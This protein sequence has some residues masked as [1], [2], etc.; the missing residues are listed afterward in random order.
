MDF[1]ASGQQAAGSP[2]IEGKPGLTRKALLLGTSLFV[3]AIAPSPAFAFAGEQCGPAPAGPGT[4][5]CT[6]AGNPYPTGIDY[7]PTPDDLTLVLDPGVV[8]VQGVQLTSTAP[9]A[10]LRVEGPVYTSIYSTSAG[11]EGVL[12]TSPNGSAYVN[13]DHVTTLGDNAIGISAAAQKFTTVIADTVLTSGTTS[14]GVQAT[15]SPSGSYAGGPVSVTVADLTTVGDNSHGIVATAHSSPA[16]AGGDVIVDAGNVSTYGNASHGIRA[17]SERDSYGNSGSVTVTA[18]RV[19][20]AGDLGIGI[21][22]DAGS[23]GVTIGSNEIIT[24]GNGSTALVGTASGNVT[25]DSAAI[26]TT[27]DD[28]LG[29]STLSQ[30]GSVDITSGTVTTS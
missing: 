6:P 8:T 13:V 10:D 15:T 17:T 25:V 14:V 26:T 2:R 27:G 22:A 29:I 18:D 11:V 21:I 16:Y 12:V 7:G 28:S 30:S 1:V 5:H 9:D 24:H 3:Y 4:V 23:G 19:F 20:T